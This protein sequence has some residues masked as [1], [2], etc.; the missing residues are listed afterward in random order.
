MKTVCQRVFVMNLGGHGESD[1]WWPLLL[2]LTIV[3]LV[4]CRSFAESSSPMFL[5]FTPGTLVEM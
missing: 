3:I 2:H 1:V 5:T 4:G